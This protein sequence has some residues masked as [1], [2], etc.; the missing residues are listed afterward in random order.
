[1]KKIAISI[2][3]ALLFPVL[4]LAQDNQ[5]EEKETIK[6]VIQRFKKDLY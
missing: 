1:M 5:N 4:M 6:T 2:F 3:L